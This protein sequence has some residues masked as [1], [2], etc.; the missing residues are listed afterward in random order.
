MLKIQFILIEQGINKD[1]IRKENFVIHQNVNAILPPDTRT[2]SVH[3]FQDSVINSFEVHYP[4][5]IL[6]AAKKAGLFLPFS[7]EAG[8]CGNCAVKCLKGEVWHAANEVLMENDLKKGM[9]LTC[10]GHPVNG[11]ITISYRQ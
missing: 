5:T 2:H 11:D 8:S 7:C 6:Q 9:I 1:D 4:H 3:I 10:T